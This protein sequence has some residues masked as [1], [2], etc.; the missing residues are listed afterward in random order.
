M[1]YKVKINKKALQDLENISNYLDY[2]FGNII[3]ND[4]RT[5]ILDSIS[6][7]QDFPLIGSIQNKERGFRGFIIHRHTTI[8]YRFVNPRVTIL[9][10]YDN[11]QKPL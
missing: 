2:T 4:F 6:L 5:K 1:A 10:F 9:R 11:R 3:A 7:L 8:V